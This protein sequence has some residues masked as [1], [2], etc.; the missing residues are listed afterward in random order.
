MYNY[1]YYF[2]YKVP[3]EKKIETFTPIARLL[4]KEQTLPMSIN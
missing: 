2:I 3:S 1:H 4:I